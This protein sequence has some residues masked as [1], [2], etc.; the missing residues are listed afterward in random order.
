MNVDAYIYIYF[1][2]CYIYIY[3]HLQNLLYASLLVSASKSVPESGKAMW[4]LLDD[5]GASTSRESVWLFTR[6][7]LCALWKNKIL[8]SNSLLSRS[9]S[10][11]KPVLSIST[12]CRLF[13]CGKCSTKGPSLIGQ[14]VAR[15][16][17][18]ALPGR[19]HDVM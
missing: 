10:L 11:V 17:P 14:H 4:L 9:C 3:T 12:K 8:G 13:S 1:F 2:L 19:L 18:S 15:C 5:M 16:G 7:D 6:L